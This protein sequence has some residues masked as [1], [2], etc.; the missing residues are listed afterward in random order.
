MKR[1]GFTLI[2][3]LVVIAIIAILAAILFPVFAAAREK[4]RQVTCLNNL[5]QLSTALNLYGGDYGQK[6]P[7]KIHNCVASLYIY[8]GGNWNSQQPLHMNPWYKN[9]VYFNPYSLPDN[10]NWWFANPKYVLDPYVHNMKLWQCPS[11]PKRRSLYGDLAYATEVQNPPPGQ[12]PA[13][14]VNCCGVRAID[15]ATCAGMTQEIMN[16]IW[17]CVAPQIFGSS[18]ACISFPSNGVGSE[19]T[20]LKNIGFSYSLFTPPRYDLEGPFNFWELPT[21]SGFTN[22]NPNHNPVQAA[23]FPW[24]FDSY[25]INHNELKNYIGPHNGGLNYGFLDGHAKWYKID[26]TPSVYQGPFAEILQ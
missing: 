7:S 22:S 10:W 9:G 16:V 14:W 13:V 2:E 1:K 18:G 24:I 8:A 19:P 17:A 3:L 5:K 26:N 15:P 6:Y 12:Y 25:N 4:A 20:P 23:Q 21:R 11:E